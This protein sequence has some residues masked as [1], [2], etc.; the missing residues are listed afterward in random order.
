MIK[1][2]ICTGIEHIGELADIGFDYIELGL[3]HISELSDEEFEKV[4]QAVDASL[5]KA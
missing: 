4:A 3:A 2:G 1:L 5:I